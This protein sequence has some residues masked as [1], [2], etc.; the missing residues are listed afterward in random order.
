MSDAAFVDMVEELDEGRGGGRPRFHRTPLAPSDALAKSTRPRR[1]AGVV[2]NE[3]ATSRLAQGAAPVRA[4]AAPRGE[5]THGPHDARGD[6]PPRA[7]DRL[8]RQR[9]AGGRGRRARHRTPARSV[10]PSGRRRACGRAA[11]ALGA[12]I[13]VCARR[14]RARRSVRARLPRGARARARCRS[15]CRATRTVSTSKAAPR[16]AGSWRRS[17]PAPAGAWTACSCR[18]AAARHAS[19]VIRACATRRRLGRIEHLPKLRTRCRPA[20]L[21]PPLR[22]AYEEI[23]RAL[24]GRARRRPDVRA[25]ARRVTRRTSAFGVAARARSPRALHVGVELAP[26]L[27]RARHPRRRDVRL[28]PRSSRACSSRRLAG[29]GGRG[30]RWPRRATWR[31]PRACPPIHGRRVARRGCSRCGACAGSAWTR[32]SW[33]C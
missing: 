20:R 3:T 24:P 17:S 30:A 12:Q 32:A 11:Q 7:R 18:S 2:K 21:L 6:E 10:H 1:G 15:A 27:D 9:G 13:A 28:V 16:S 31:R 22:R 8:V 19:G 23:R 14:G 26:A 33:C 4:R 29:R 25:F 5:R